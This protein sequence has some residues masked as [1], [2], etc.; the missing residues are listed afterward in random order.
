MDEI[1]DAIDIVTTAT[2]LLWIRKALMCATGEP[3]RSYLLPPGFVVRDLSKAESRAVMAD[4]WEERG[5]M[6]RA[7]ILRSGDGPPVVEVEVPELFDSYD[8]QE[9]FGEGSGNNCGKD[10]IEVCPPELDVKVVA[11]WQQAFGEDP[12]SPAKPGATL[13]MVPMLNNV[14]QIVAAVNGQNDGPSWVGLFL[15]KDGSWVVAEGSCDYTGWDCQAGNNLYVG[16]SLDDVVR[17]GLTPDNRTRLRIP[18]PMF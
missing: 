6:T 17:Y 18:F 8:W 4:W 7:Q 10:S 12:E 2:D 9:V 13:I 3:E 16:L 1:P 11:L 14:D 5:E 15:M